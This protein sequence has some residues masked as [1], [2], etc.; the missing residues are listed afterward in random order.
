MLSQSD[1]QW[2]DHLLPVRMK[3][4]SMH[5]DNRTALALF[6]LGVDSQEIILSIIKPGSVTIEDGVNYLLGPA[7]FFIKIRCI[8]TRC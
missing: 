2:L 6:G 1:S 3:T 7:F 8:S 4:R 5:D